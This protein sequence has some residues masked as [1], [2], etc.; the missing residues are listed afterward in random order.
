M[1]V[2]E[3]K[4][5]YQE[6]R[7]MEFDDND[8]FWYELI[9]GELVKKQSPT[10]DHQDISRELGFLLIAYTKKT[11]AGI[12]YHAPL[13]VV[14]DDG[15]AYHPDI[16]F[17]RRERF[18]IIDDKEKI[19]IGAPDLVIEILSKSTASEDR[20]DKK[21]NYEKFGV[22]EYWLVDPQ[23]K[24]FEV[25]SLVNDRF[26]LTAYLE[27]SGVLKSSALEGFEMDL[28]KLFADATLAESNS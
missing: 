18:F 20:G 27:G 17:I 16:F 28:E 14:L 11:K 26:K 9:N 21:D 12:I 10:T 24:S 13:D 19:V 25:Y 6:F 8:P 22:R 5:T 3:K 2:L 15:N 7:E 4:L 1:E 23:K